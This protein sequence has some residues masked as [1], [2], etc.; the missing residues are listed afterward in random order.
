[1]D[2]LDDAGFIVDVH[3]TDQKGVRAEIYLILQTK[4]SRCI[5]VEVGDFNA[6][7][8]EVF[9]CKDGLVLG[10]DGDEVAASV[11]VGLHP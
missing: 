2:V 7:S 8:F 11:S 9:V 1:M 3:R 6:M 4:S 10:F 5:Y